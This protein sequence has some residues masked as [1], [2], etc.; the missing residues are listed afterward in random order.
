MAGTLVLTSGAATRLD[1]SHLAGRDAHDLRA[2]IHSSPP[3]HATDT[4]N[5]WLTL[6]EFYL[7][8]CCTHA[9]RVW[10]YVRARASAA[11][12]YRDHT[13]GHRNSLPGRSSRYGAAGPYAG[14]TGAYPE[15]PRL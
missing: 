1:H 8:F 14:A 12:A 9:N 4:R 2:P 5:T 11:K 10:T 6:T 3:T 13:P 7:H 15:S